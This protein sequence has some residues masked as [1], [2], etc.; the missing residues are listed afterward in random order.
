MRVLAVSLDPRN[1]LHI[2][3]RGTRDQ[4]RAP[5][6]Y[7]MFVAVS[8]P[9]ILS[10]LN[11]KVL[12]LH[13]KLPIGIIP[14]F[15]GQEKFMRIELGSAPCPFQNCCHRAMLYESKTASKAMFSG[16]PI[17]HACREVE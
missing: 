8:S 16:S 15:G 14:S 6:S 1:F 4:P 12:T 5:Y 3:V 7:S 10:K 2:S 11:S 17:L 9:T 13:V